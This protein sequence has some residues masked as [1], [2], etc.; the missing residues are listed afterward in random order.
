M[1]FQDYYKTLGVARTATA[2]EIKRAYRTLAKEWHPDRHPPHRREE[3]EQRFKAIAEANEVLSD[4]EK[5]KRYDQLGEHWR[6][7]Q[8]FQPPPGGGG[9]TMDAEEFARMFGGA[10]GARG[11]GFGGGG[12]SDFFAQMFGDMFAGR[13]RGGPGAGAGAR[14]RRPSRGDDVEADLEL[15]VGEALRSGKRAFQLRVSQPC[16]VCGGEGCPSCGGLGHTTSTRS[17]DLSIPKDV[18][19]GQV[20]RLRGLGQPAPGGTAG[21]LLLRLHLVADDVHRLRGDDVEAD[22]VVAPWEALDGTSVDVQ[23]PGGTATVKIPA[24][25]RAGERLRLRGQGL[26]TPGGGRSDLILVVRLALPKD[27]TDA[28]KAQLRE[29]GKSAGAVRGG[30]GR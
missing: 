9:R 12:F 13:G 29:L 8:D 28:Q 26:S 7:G 4:P 23:V 1:Q 14:A 30:V 25:T 3:A 22:L 20:L 6:H 21:D 16:A 18:R 2:D 19:D 27:L 24:G 5:R 17:V 15:S 11:G 10:G